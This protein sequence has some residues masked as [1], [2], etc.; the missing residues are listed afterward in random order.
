ML[1]LNVFIAKSLTIFVILLL[2]NNK[3]LTG[4]SESVYINSVKCMC[5]P[6][7]L[8][9]I[10]FDI[11]DAMK[12]TVYQTRKNWPYV[13]QLIALFLFGVCADVCVY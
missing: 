4:T 5:V 1:L 9:V 12:S 10:I 8:P 7:L 11:S 13:F 2:R 6:N 3:L